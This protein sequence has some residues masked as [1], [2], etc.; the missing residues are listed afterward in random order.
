MKRFIILACLL[1][2]AVPIFAYCNFN[3]ITEYEIYPEYKYEG[4][5]QQNFKTTVLNEYRKE[6]YPVC[7]DKIK[8]S[9]EI[10]K[11]PNKVK[12]KNQKTEERK[13]RD[14]MYLEYSN[15][16]LTIEHYD[17][18]DTYGYDERRSRYSEICNN[19]VRKYS[20]EYSMPA[21]LDN[22]SYYDA[23]PKLEDI[24][25]SRRIEYLE[26]RNNTKKYVEYDKFGKITQLDNKKVLYREDGSL[27]KI[28][29]FKVSTGNNNICYY[30]WG[31]LELNSFN[32]I[33]SITPLD[34][35]YKSEFIV[36]DT[37]ELYE[38]YLKMLSDNFFNKYKYYGNRYSTY[39]NFFKLKVEGKPEVIKAKNECNLNFANFFWIYLNYVYNPTEYDK[40]DSIDRYWFK[41]QVKLTE[42]W[43]KTHKIGYKNPYEERFRNKARTIVKESKSD[44]VHVE[45]EEERLRKEVKQLNEQ[46]NNLQRQQEYMERKQNEQIQYIDGQ[47]VEYD[48]WGRIYSIGGKRVQY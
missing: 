3:S 23:N 26:S 38:Y 12:I 4:S 1:F 8:V 29:F 9:K 44:Y 39:T 48:S 31:R 18:Q 42:E 2:L 20:H 22:L 36:Y 17:N 37:L 24:I 25:K 43:M 6:E 16:Y 34:V 5:L 19:L 30:G 15:E 47:K 14:K 21:L 13:K 11:E 35:E 7:T 40:L 33:I 45:T 10:A 41:E 27:Y 46:I 32:E 28:G